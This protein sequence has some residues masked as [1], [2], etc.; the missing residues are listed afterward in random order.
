MSESESKPVI[1]VSILAGALQYKLRSIRL[2]EDDARIQAQSVLN[3]FGFNL[4][5]MDMILKPHDRDVFYQLEDLGF[6][7][8]G[9]SQ[10]FLYTPGRNQGSD[11]RTFLWE[12]RVDNIMEAY[13]NQ[14]IL[15]VKRV[16]TKLKVE[17]DLA[18]CY[19]EV[20]DDIWASHIR[21]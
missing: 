8:S 12:Q 2:S 10:F 21:D 7:K 15:G 18:L 17:E 11:W 6:L 16:E 4:T 20:P 5:T 3:F 9:R 1:T 19:Q 13:N 14:L